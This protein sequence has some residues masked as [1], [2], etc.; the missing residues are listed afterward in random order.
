MEAKTREKIFA[1]L[2]ENLRA[3][4]LRTASA[5]GGLEC[6]SE[7]KLRTAYASSAVLSGERVRL[8]S[9]VGKEALSHALEV[10]S[11]GA[12][13][14]HRDT[15]CRGYVSLKSG[16]RVGICGTARYDGGNI[17]GVS[18]VSSLVFRMPTG[19]FDERRGLLNAFV[20]CKRGIMIYSP[21]GVGKTSALRA[22]AHDLSVIGE[23][24]AVVD[25]RCE[26]N[27]DDYR[28]DSVDILRGFKRADG[29]EIALRTLSPSV[30]LVDEVGR[31]DEATA[32][33][34]ALSSGV[35]IAVTAHAGSAEDVFSRIALRP[36]FEH[37]AIDRLVGIKNQGGKRT[38][39]V[40]EV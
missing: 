35:R 34:E 13:Y 33:L 28:R 24:V 40:T 16:V 14:S 12:I 7:L 36:F 1:A 31:L 17:V 2:P 8:Y 30:I 39:T 15:I 6:M 11:D 9:Q 38:L 10:L 18:D 37:G 21:P 29:I 20:G 19:H 3:E 4:L 23:E 25:E 22:L 27:E 32:M 26:F 5:R